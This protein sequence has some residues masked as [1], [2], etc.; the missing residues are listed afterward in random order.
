MAARKTPLRAVAPDEK[1][2][3]RKPLS[4]TEAAASGDYRVLLEAQRMDIARSLQDPA[5]Q[6]PA[7]AALHRQL[8]LIAKELREM[9]AAAEEEAAENGATPDEAFDASAV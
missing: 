8:G 3:K 2:A 5:T 4:L 9:D 7:R 1:P 6:G